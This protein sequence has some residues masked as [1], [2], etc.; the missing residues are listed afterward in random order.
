L[1]TF[2]LLA[3]ARGA[4]EAGGTAPCVFNAANEIAVAAFLGGRLPFLEI[5]GVVE[6]TLAAAD[7]SAARDLDDLISADADARRLADGTLTVA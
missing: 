2:P 1:E 3:L 4:G 7:T 5:A 6:E